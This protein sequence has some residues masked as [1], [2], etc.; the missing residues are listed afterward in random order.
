MEDIAYKVSITTISTRQV[1]A[2][3]YLC[4]LLSVLFLL[5]LP[6]IV[7][8]STNL[9]IA[10]VR[11][12]RKY[13]YES[14]TGKAKVKLKL[15]LK[16]CKVSGGISLHILI[17]GTRWG[18]W[19]GSCPGRFNISE[20]GSDLNSIGRW[21]GPRAWLDAVVRSKVAV[22]ARNRTP[23]LRLSTMQLI[24][25]IYGAT[26]RKYFTIRFGMWLMVWQICVK[27]YHGVRFMAPNHLRLKCKSAAVIFRIEYRI[28]KTGE[29]RN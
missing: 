16:M 11:Y 8:E 19:L 2:Y 5:T 21:V 6:Y 17:L 28:Y 4:Q 1:L 22:H 12:A 20:R 7:S 23:I 18:E 9:F 24:L 14:H 15:S 3:N 27:F 13:S 29:S 25:Y 26:V 10:L